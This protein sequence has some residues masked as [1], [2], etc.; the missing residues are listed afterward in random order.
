[1]CKYK[2]NLEQYFNI[3][4]RNGIKEGEY[5][6]LFLISKDTNIKTQKHYK[7]IQDTIKDIDKLKHYNNIFVSLSTTDGKGRATGNLKNRSVL[8]FDFDK[9]DYAEGFN[10]KDVLNRFRKL[11][12]YYHMLIDS[13]HGYHA[14]VLC[15]N[16]TDI[17]KV[18][19]VNKAIATRLGADIQA[20]KNTQVLRVPGTYNY[21]DKPKRVN[22]IWL[23]S[24][25]NKLIRYGLDRQ[26]NKFCT[27]TDTNIKY[28]KNNN[29]P[30]CIKQMLEGVEKGHR[31][32]VLGRLTKWLQSNNYSK[33]KAFEII[34]E[35]NNKC[36][37][38]EDIAVLKNNF[39][40]YWNKD[41]KLLGCISQNADIQA[42]LSC[43]CDKYN[44]NKNDKYEII[45]AGECVEIE[46]KIANKIKYRGDKVMIDGNHIAIISILKIHKG[47]LNTNELKQ[48][49]ISTITKKPRMSKPTLI[50][51]LKELEQ[52]DIVECIKNKNKT[53]PS[54]YKLKDV[55]ALENEKFNISYHAVQRYIDR[56]IGQ[57]ALRIYIYMLYKLS[58]G[59]NVVQEDLG[60]DLGITQQAISRGI[61]EL[62]KARYLVIETDYSINPL[63]VN[64][65]KWL[66]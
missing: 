49:L 53:I 18:V 42:I 2:Y 19:S 51:V 25:K 47:G 37:P 11:G 66:I 31:N 15:D 26:Y 4:F 29:M 20:V 36:S 57:N 21:K 41:Y 27:F 62:E 12:I 34:K 48:E 14:Y 39:N 8:A 1:M 63:G 56:A 16:T 40:D 22:I 33:S 43:Y 28:I 44:C 13:G 32:F 65:Y 52:M 59:D 50:K 38:I 46:Y 6:T 5:I 7:S 9:K 61:T 55:K 17:N 45:I 23:Q 35:W 24:D 30:Y 10:H 54:L 58:K 60:K 64:R 3:L